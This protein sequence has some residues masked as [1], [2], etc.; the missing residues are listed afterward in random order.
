MARPRIITI[1]EWLL[2]TSHALGVSTESL[3]AEIDV[4]ALHAAL[5]APAAGYRD[6]ALYRDLPDQAAALVEAILTRP[7][8]A[9]E[10]RLLA[11]ATLVLFLGHN[12]AE[13]VVS[14]TERASFLVD[15]GRPPGSRR[16]I[17]A[18]IEAHLRRTGIQPQPPTGSESSPKPVGCLA[19]PVCGVRDSPD[20]VARLHKL[21]GAL[22]HAVCHFTFEGSGAS[23]KLEIAALEYTQATGPEVDYADE[24]DRFLSELLA[25]EPDDKLRYKLLGHLSIA[26]FLI[27]VGDRMASF[28]AGF[29]FG[30][31]GHSTPVLYLNPKGVRR[32]RWI[33]DGAL[34]AHLE[35]IEFE[36]TT[37]A[38]QAAVAWLTRWYPVIQRRWREWQARMLRTGAVA[39]SF[40]TAW[41]HLASREGRL[42]AFARTGLPVNTFFA[43]LHP[44]GVAVASLEDLQ[45]MACGLGLSLPALMAGNQGEGLD[46]TGLARE[47]APLTKREYGAFLT[48]WEIADWDS[49]R[50]VRALA[51]GRAMADRRAALGRAGIDARQSLN[52]HTAWLRIDTEL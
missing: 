52:H 14:S 11:F 38:T 33:G 15:A 26:S 28:G 10:R 46:L 5:E 24:T 6:R 20:D 13:L 4:E 17:A 41:S 42:E 3:L 22:D 7:P 9:R 29:E 8:L 19:M 44:D 49:D 45:A 2:A 32:S 31:V 16:E 12:E 1:R 43:L 25:P 34:F 35:V 48:A 21:A 40:L 36:D 47:I 23:M 39:L 27:I 51:T 37:D 30:R 50:A 18:W